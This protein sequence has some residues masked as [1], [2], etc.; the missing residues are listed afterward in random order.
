MIA[1]LLPVAS[2]SFELSTSD[3]MAMLYSPQLQFSVDGDP[4]VKIGLVDDRDEITFRPDGPIRVLPLGEGGPEILLPGGK[5]YRVSLVEGAPGDYRY[6]ATVA[7]FLPSE[8]R[9]AAEAR[10]LWE[11]R[12]YTTETFAL[13]SLFAI[14]GN[15]FD[16]RQTI[17]AVG[18]LSDRRAVQDVANELDR[19]Y[20]IS[21]ELHVELVEYPTGEL[22]LESDDIEV[23]IEHHDLIWIAADLDTVFRIDGDVFEGLA[24]GGR[25]ND[26]HYTGSLIFTIDRAGRLSLVNELPAEQLLQGILP[27]E[28]YASAPIA[29]LHAQAVAARGE[30]LADLGVRYLADPYMTC[31]T[32]SC[33][34]YRGIDLED[35]RASRAV[36]E[37]RGVVL[38]GEG[39]IARTTYSASCGGFAGDYRST[40]GHE[41]VSHLSYHY[42]GPAE[43]NAYEDGLDE[44]NI[45]EFLSAEPPTYD[46]IEDFGGARLYRWSVERTADELTASV[47]ERY[48]VGRVTGIEILERD[49]SGRVVR[50]SIQGEDGA[51][52]IERELPIRRAFGGLRSAMF[53][54]DI[55]E[56]DDGSIRHAT[57]TGGGFGHGVG[58]CQTGSIGAAQ[59][60]LDYTQILS[61]YYPGTA[62]QQLW[63]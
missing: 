1:S 58:L 55:R 59:R 13:G 7:A 40:W 53:V 11:G 5:D 56:N 60:G 17:V 29:A 20:G 19:E 16:N 38:M 6:W 49:R 36:Q 22:R 50:L 30:L 14:R 18:G 3:R 24:D 57:F 23:V 47:N 42:D 27:A 63:Q 54:L 44:D 48:A 21:P 25:G 51:V 35:A 43:S 62:I 45:R 8:R 10:T 33:Q 52:V 9:E 39:H 2:S 12:E 46:N 61:H 41:S 37:T 4:M 31:S 28:I 15:M 34:V 32:T 26:R